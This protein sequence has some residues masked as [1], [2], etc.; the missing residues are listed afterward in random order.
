MTER[1]QNL[2][3]LGVDQLEPA[4]FQPR[5]A[6]DETDL[7]ELTE[8]IRTRGILQ[9]ILVRPM[10]N[11]E[12]TFQIIAGERRWRAASGRACMKCRCTYATWMMR[13]PWRQ[14]WLKTCNAPIS[15][16]LKKQRG[17]SDFRRIS[18]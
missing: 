8:S 10:P 1:A 12:N 18:P 3:V 11:Q 14:P 2:S 15:T 5:Q 17:S 9:P 4:R 6:I 16:P 7:V 13:T